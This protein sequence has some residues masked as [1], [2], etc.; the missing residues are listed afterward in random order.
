MVLKVWL[1]RRART[2]MAEIRDYLLREAAAA[3][4][5]R[6]R[7]HLMD[8][9]LRLANSPRPG[10]ST[11]EPGIRVPSPTPNPY[12]VYFTATADTVIILHIRH[13]ARRAPK[14]DE[15]A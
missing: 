2:D 12:R 13:T 10:I 11:S 7:K 5:E 1:H 4:A 9:I 14:A 8:R 6:V 3:S 15:I